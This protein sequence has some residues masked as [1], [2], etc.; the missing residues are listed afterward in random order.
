MSTSMQ[1]KNTLFKTNA[2]SYCQ[3][4]LVPLGQGNKQNRRRENFSAIA[5]VITM[6]GGGSVTSHEV[7]PH[8]LL[9]R[10]KFRYP[11]IGGWDDAF[12]FAASDYGV[13]SIVLSSCHFI[14]ATIPPRGSC[15]LPLLSG[16]WVVYFQSER[17]NT[18]QIFL[19]A[20]ENDG[21]EKDDRC[22]N[23]RR[24]QIK[25]NTRGVRLE[26]LFYKYQ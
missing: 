17:V 10:G 18:R 14:H 6:V 8:W 2:W 24:M 1:K 15:S 19:S 23:A 5:F 11:M 16:R 7:F 4:D 26:I 21:N 13:S 22:F 12:R 3:Q 25:R 9:S 20:I